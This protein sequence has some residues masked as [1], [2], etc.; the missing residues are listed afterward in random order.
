MYLTHVLLLNTSVLDKS[1]MSYMDQR[2]YL[3]CAPIHFY[4]VTMDM[5]YSIF[6]YLVHSTSYIPFVLP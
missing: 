5:L 1:K 4:F 6:M 2:D 3:F